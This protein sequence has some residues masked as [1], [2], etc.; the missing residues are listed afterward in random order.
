MAPGVL[1]AEAYGIRTTADDL[2]RFVKA[3]MGLI[4]IEPNWRRAILNTHAG[5]YRVDTMTQDLIWEQYPQ[6]V[7]LDALLAG[8][9]PKM[10]YEANP[11]ATLD[12]PLPPQDA[13]LINKTGSTNGFSAY[14]AF[15]TAKKTG[16]VL[17][18]D[19]GDPIDARVT[20][21]YQILMRLGADSRVP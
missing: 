17:L 11:A 18:A 20:A 6:P 7:G 16:I 3:N 9:S 10:A 15:M 2:L 19:E 14:V 5:Y 4:E 13:V 12:P 8:N 21:A 1:S